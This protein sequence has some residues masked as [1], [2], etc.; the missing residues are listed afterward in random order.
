MEKDKDLT[1]E[2]L[3]LQVCEQDGHERQNKVFVGCS[4]R[5]WQSLSEILRHCLDRKQDLPNELFLL[6]R[7]LDES[8][9]L[10]LKS[11]VEQVD[12]EVFRHCLRACD[13]SQQRVQVLN[14]REAKLV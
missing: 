12:S 7:A 14:F 10:S 1:C 13:D 11:P 9:R 4:E 6:G 2:L 3:V 8:L 5:L